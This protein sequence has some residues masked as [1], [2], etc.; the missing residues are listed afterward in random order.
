MR[1]SMFNFA[2]L[3][4]FAV[5]PFATLQTTGAQQPAAAQTYRVPDTQ[6]KQL[7]Q[8][9]DAQD[10][11]SQEFNRLEAQ[12]VIVTQRAALELGLTAKQLDELELVVDGLGF[13][14]RPALKKV[15]PVKTTNP[16]E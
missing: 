11:L 14:F 2:F 6:D 16:K 1:R 9:V 13:F 7:R 15:D 10:K 5:L 3:L 12:K 4:V 8:I